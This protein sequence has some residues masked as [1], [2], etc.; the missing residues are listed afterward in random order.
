MKI[1][2]YIIA[3]AAALTAM[4][5]TAQ[6]DGGEL[7]APTQ[8]QMD[9]AA[10]DV[11]KTYA[12]TKAEQAPFK[13]VIRDAFSIY[14]ATDGVA[15]GYTSE[16]MPQ[17]TDSIKKLE[18]ERRSAD[19][20]LNG[21]RKELRNLRK[22]D[23]DNRAKA[24]EATQ[25]QIENIDAEIEVV[26]LQLAQARQADSM[27]RADIEQMRNEV[28]AVN[29]SSARLSATL[30]ELRAEHTRGTEVRG[31][32]DKRKSSADSVVNE[33]RKLCE[34]MSLSS[35]ETL[36]DADLKESEKILASNRA[37]LENYRPDLIP[38]AESIIAREQVMLGGADLVRQAIAAMEGKYDAAR[39]AKL[40]EEIERY[41]RNEGISDTQSREMDTI[42][43]EL[44][45]QG[46]NVSAMT[47]MLMSFCKDDNN[48]TED[49]VAPF[50]KKIESVN[51]NSPH[52]KTLHSVRTEFIER[53]K[54][55]AKTNT[56]FE[57][58]EKNFQKFINSL[59]AKL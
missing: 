20:E 23:M 19:N 33:I 32:I 43:K 1:L 51:I 55:E 21:L 37:M 5:A 8:K 24:S 30:T 44:A 25:K 7:F 39:N 47:D 36:T 11:A 41:R 10:E 57:F 6:S 3:T 34:R 42:K 49:Q 31:E 15:S 13:K 38:V 52:F 14:M 46:Q 4:T 50:I 35:I 27:L 48:L 59:I 17:L 16:T 9:D 40:A 54:Q 2:K 58:N 56:Y 29:E 22:A 18:A 28:K 53:I 45:F 26:K 12:K